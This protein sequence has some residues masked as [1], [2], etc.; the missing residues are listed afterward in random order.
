MGQYCGSHFGLPPFLKEKN[1]LMRSPCLCV[2][3]YQLLN[4]LTDLY[5]S[6]QGAHNVEE[7]LDAMLLIL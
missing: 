3:P 7:D 6:Q 2:P 4:Q 1:R 5:E